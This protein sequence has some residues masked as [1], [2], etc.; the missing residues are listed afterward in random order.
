VVVWPTIM[1]RAFQPMVPIAPLCSR[2]K[3]FI[4]D[5]VVLACAEADTATSAHARIMFRMD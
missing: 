4:S 2:A 1:L 5:D 3:L